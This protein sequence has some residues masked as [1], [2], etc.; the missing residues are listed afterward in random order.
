MSNTS[1]DL[2]MERAQECIEYFEG[3]LPA[4]LIEKDIEDNDLGSLSYHVKQ[5]EAEMS[6]QEFYDYEILGE[7]DEY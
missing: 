7:R 3:K 2:L 6:R 5:A 1:N 4:N